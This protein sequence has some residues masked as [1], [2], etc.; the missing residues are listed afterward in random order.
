M[1]WVAL[2]FSLLDIG[3]GLAGGASAKK[4]AREAAAEEARLEGIV[5]EAK[6][7]DLKAEERH[8]M[9]KTVAASAGSNVKA[10]RGSP[11]QILME[12]AREFA[13]EKKV[14]AEAGASRAAQAKTRG[15]MIGDQAMYAAYGNAVKGLANAFSL[16]QK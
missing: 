6:L 13:R 14:V 10:D 7:R 4:N 9:G 15:S 5:T 11:L 8:M 2:A 16:F 1:Q 3:I 12:Q